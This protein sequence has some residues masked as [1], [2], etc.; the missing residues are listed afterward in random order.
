MIWNRIRE[1]YYRSHVK[2]LLRYRSE[3]LTEAA[4]I[5]DEVGRTEA[6]LVAVQREMFRGR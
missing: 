4:G 1:W 2:N 3:L 6:K 5:T